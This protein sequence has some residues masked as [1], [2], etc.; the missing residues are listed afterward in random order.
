MHYSEI[1]A[2]KR[3]WR[4]LL[5]GLL[6]L[7]VGAGNYYV[8]FVKVPEYQSVVREKKEAL[9]SY[10]GLLSESAVQAQIVLKKSVK[11]RNY[12][13]LV[14]SAGLVLIMTGLVLVFIGVARLK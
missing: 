12:Y 4:I 10:G 6:L 2:R 3:A 7:L 8:G 9:V 5:P 1:K 13:N 11:R 14:K